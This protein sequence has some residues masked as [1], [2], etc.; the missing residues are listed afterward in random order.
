MQRR[1]FLKFIFAG[2]GAAA[3]VAA[4]TTPSLALTTLAPLEPPTGT[5]HAAP[6]SAV[7]TQEDMERVE[8]EK[9]YWGYRRRYWRPRRHYWRRHYYPVYRRRYWRPRYYRRRYYY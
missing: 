1:A 5:P 2:A 7:A 4:S 6:E 9:S 3:A 8:I